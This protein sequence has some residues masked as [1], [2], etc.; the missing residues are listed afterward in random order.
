MLNARTDSELLVMLLERLPARLL[1]N[2]S[3]QTLVMEMLTVY[4]DSHLPVKVL[5]TPWAG[6][7]LRPRA[8]AAKLVLELP[9]EPATATGNG[10]SQMPMAPL[11][12]P[13]MRP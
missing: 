2:C 6:C 12:W 5:A 4:T 13:R 7:Q 8:A 10:D 9:H 11:A 1:P 3:A